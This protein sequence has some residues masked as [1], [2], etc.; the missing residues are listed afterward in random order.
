MRHAGDE[1]AL[2]RGG[3]RDEDDASPH[4]MATIWWDILLV[5]APPLMSP[6]RGLF[7]GPRE[8]D[9][10]HAGPK[11]LCRWLTLRKPSSA[12]GIRRR[13]GSDATWPAPRV[14]V[15]P[16][17]DPLHNSIRGAGE[18]SRGP[19]SQPESQR[20]AVPRSRDA[21]RTAPAISRGGAS[22]AVWRG[23]GPPGATCDEPKFEFCVFVPASI[24]LSHN[25]DDTTT[26][27]HGTTQYCVTC[28]WCSSLSTPSRNWPWRTMG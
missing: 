21:K 16:P 26:T 19:E 13:R 17:K 25:D 15:R 12:N 7:Q 5:S 8:L 2:S 27:Q 28:S 14:A 22:A 20:T 9:V 4:L 11:R 10:V 18:Q 6:P 23:G 24:P 1:V 3:A